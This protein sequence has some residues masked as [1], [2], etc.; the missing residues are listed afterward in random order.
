MTCDDPGF[1]QIAEIAADA[2]SYSD[3]TTAENTTYTYRVRAYN[4]GGNSGYSN[5]DDATTPVAAPTVLTVTGTTASSVSLGWTDNSGAEDGFGVERCTGTAAACNDGDFTEIT[6]TAAN[7]VIYTDATAAATTTYTYRVRA[8]KAGGLDSGY[9]NEAE[10]TT[11][12]VPVPATPTGLAATAISAAQVDLGW[13]DVATTETGYRVERCTGTTVTCDDGGFGQIAEIAADAISYSDGTTAENTTYTYRVRAYNAGGN[14]GYS[15]EDDAA[16]PVAAPT[17]LT[18]TGTTASS[19]SLGWTDNSGAEDGFGVERCTGTAAACND[20]DFTEITQTAANA[21]IYTDATAAATTTYTYRVRALK[22]GGLD[23]GYSN[24]AEGTT[25]A[26]PV[27]ATPT[28]LAATAISAAQVDLGWTD[29]ATTETGYRV[30]R[31][32]GTT[33]TCDDGGFGQIAEIAADA[34]S[35][36]DG[37]TAENTTYTY[38]VRAYNAGGNSGYSN[39]DDAATPVAA[40][41]VLTVTGTTA[42]SV[43]LGWTDNSGAEDGFGVERCTGTAAA[44]NDGDFT[45]ITQTAANAVIYTDATAAATTTYTYRVRALKAGGLD[46]GY[47]NEAQGTTSAVPVPA[48]PTGLAA[49]AISAAQVDLGWTDVATTETGY[50]VE[51]CTGTTVTCDDG[52]FG[53]IA[54]IAADAISYS[55]GTTAENTTYTYRV[56][57]YNAGGN[58]GYSNEDDAA[59]PVAAPTVLTVTGT[60]ASSVS[61]G[62]TD[63]S[64]AEDGFGVERCTGTAAACNDGDFTEITQTAANTVIYTDATAAATTT[65]TYRVRALKAGGLDSGYSNEAQGTTSAVPVPATPTGL[66]ATAISAAQVDLGWTDVATTETGYRVERCTGTTVTCDDGGFGQIAEIAADAISYSDGTT[67]ENTTYTYRV[68]AY[69]AGG[70]SGYSNEDDAATP[71]AAPTVLTVTGTTASSVSLGWTDNSGAEDGFGVE[72]CTGT[73][74]ACN[75][76]DFTEITQTAANTVIYTDATAAATTTYT[77]RVRALKA[78]GLDSGYSNEAEGTTSAVPLTEGPAPPPPNVP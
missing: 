15:N 44:C 39:E 48:T 42:S 63:N 8:L 78:G 21:V 34:I 9:S 49:T 27:P 52:G 70:N 2:V 41:T 24:E 4:A 59:T 22:A 32:T 50:R 26:V 72:R 10:G 37:T 40:P 38:R 65:Y 58:S 23:S 71:V 18:V 57:A 45:E 31:C 17:V 46:S 33:V 68:R 11:S 7:A 60:T 62:W 28:G 77:Y 47:S 74:A 25:S 54:E 43:S 67:A 1:A 16:T 13:T 64:G 76:G 14:S 66:A 12:A 75:D 3:G 30:E 73:A 20:G 53:Q 29:V 19:V 6:Q 5:E 55:D 51:R 35:Y 56:R 61:L 36:S 69:N